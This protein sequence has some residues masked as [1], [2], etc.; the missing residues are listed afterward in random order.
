MFQLLMEVKEVWPPCFSLISFES[1]NSAVSVEQFGGKC[2]P[3]K[4]NKNTNNNDNNNN[5]Q[6]YVE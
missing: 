1:C 3:G 5:K 6:Y 2:S 4:D